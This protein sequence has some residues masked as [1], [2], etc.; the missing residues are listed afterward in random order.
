MNAIVALDRLPITC[1][2]G[3]LPEERVNLQEIFLDVRLQVD[4]SEA[5]ET[6]EV[7]FTVNYAELADELTEFVIEQRFQLIET[8]AARC[9]QLV[10]ANHPRVDWCEIVVNKPKAVPRAGGTWVSVEV[11]RDEAEEE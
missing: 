10:L 1:I 4:V 9:G 11:Y 3:I 8:M 6:E 2:V 5:V 7:E